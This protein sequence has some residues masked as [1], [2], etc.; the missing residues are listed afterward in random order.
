MIEILLNI[1][2]ILIVIYLLISVAFSFYLEHKLNAWI[3]IFIG[4][5][6]PYVAYVAWKKRDE[7]IAEYI[8]R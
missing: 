8:D 7:I 3:P 4:M 2:A 1:I 5:L 6:W